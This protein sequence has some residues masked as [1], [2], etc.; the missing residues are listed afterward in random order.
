[1]KPMSE[2]P[3]DPPKDFAHSGKK[4][5]T[6]ISWLVLALIAIPAAIVGFA[7][8]CTGTMAAVV[9]SVNDPTEGQMMLLPI[10]GFVG[11]FIG[12]AL[13]FWIGSK[14]IQRRKN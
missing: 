4:K 2:N 10:M 3:F 9:F 11:A 13:V 1:M 14:K 6:W 5:P 8:S 7:I 12:V